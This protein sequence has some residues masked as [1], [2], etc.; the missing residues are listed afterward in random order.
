MKT[1]TFTTGIRLFA[2]GDYSEEAYRILKGTV[3]ISVNEGKTAVVLGTL[4]EG[5]IF[6]E[7]G[8]IEHMPR[9]ASARALTDL[10]VEVIAEEDFNQSLVGGSDIWVP[11]L[12]TIFERLRVANE[13]LRFAEE[14]LEA[15]S[16]PASLTKS[17]RLAV[18]D[19]SDSLMLEPDSEETRLQSALQQQALNSFPFALGRRAD[20]A[21]CVDVFSKSHLLIGDRMPFRV[22]RSHCVIEREK[23]AYFIQDRG[24]KLGTIINGISIGGS[25]KESRV[26]L[27]TG[28]NTLVLGPANST[29]RFILTVPEV[30]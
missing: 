1:E 12:T 21:A 30:D 3:E 22:S 6:G 28:P 27:R 17:K 29:I 5:E 2:Q 7:M 4:G 19:R 9:S 11:Y 25:S 14:Q 26:R 20:L 16:T 13:R 24:S 15:F 23:G 18:V 10:T 8:M